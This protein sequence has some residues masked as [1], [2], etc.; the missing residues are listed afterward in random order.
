MHFFQLISHGL[1]SHGKWAGLAYSP[2]LLF[3]EFKRNIL[4]LF[5]IVNKIHKHI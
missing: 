2:F 3:R 1:W 4:V 5:P